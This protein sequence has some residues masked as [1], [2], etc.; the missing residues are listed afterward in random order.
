MYQTDP[1]LLKYTGNSKKKK[2]FFMWDIMKFI[3]L[4]I[5]IGKVKKKSN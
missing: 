3:Y 1:K 4:Y 2:N 5:K